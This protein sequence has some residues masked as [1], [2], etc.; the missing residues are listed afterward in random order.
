METNDVN[1]LNALCWEMNDEKFI[2]ILNLFASNIHKDSDGYPTVY[3]N[4]KLTRVLEPDPNNPTE[5][6]FHK[7]VEPLQAAGIKVVAGDKGAL[8]KHEDACR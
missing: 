1:P 2:D 8:Q 3:L 4:D 5:T 6:G 7:Y